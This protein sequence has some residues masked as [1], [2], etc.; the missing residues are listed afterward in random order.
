MHCLHKQETE[1]APVSIMTDW[2]ICCNKTYRTVFLHRLMQFLQ[3]MSIHHRQDDLMLIFRLKFLCKFI[4]RSPLRVSP[5]FISDRNF[6]TTLFH[7][8]APPV[9]ITCF[10]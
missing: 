10:L 3:K 2:I 7:T 5:G 4:V 6:I 8:A 1:A 9:F